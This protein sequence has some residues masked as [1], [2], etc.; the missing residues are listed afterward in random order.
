MKFVQKE[1]PFECDGCPHQCVTFNGGKSY[2]VNGESS[3]HIFLNAGEFAPCGK[4]LSQL[5][6]VVQSRVYMEWNKK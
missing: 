3:G 2:A 5:K 4:Q 1:G 6:K